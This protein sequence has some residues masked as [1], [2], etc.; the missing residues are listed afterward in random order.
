MD[1]SASHAHMDTYT[2]RDEYRVL[3]AD[4]G[5]PIGYAIITRVHPDPHPYPCRDADPDPAADGNCGADYPDCAGRN[6][7]SH[8]GAPGGHGAHLLRSDLGQ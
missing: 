8:G 1:A 5:T 7:H 4:D 2:L 3:Y 6:G